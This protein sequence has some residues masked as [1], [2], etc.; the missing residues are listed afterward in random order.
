M[1]MLLIFDNTAVVFCKDGI[2][3]AAINPQTCA[4]LVTVETVVTVVTV[5]LEIVTAG[6]FT[7]ETRKSASIP[8]TAP[9]TFIDCTA[10]SIASSH[11]LTDFR[12]VYAILCYIVSCASVNNVD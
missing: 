8:R 7:T 10:S 2:C 11:S 12:G 4:W 6:V 1:L 3:G 5:P 9:R